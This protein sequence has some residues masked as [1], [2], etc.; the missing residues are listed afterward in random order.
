VKLNE[1]N[2]FLSACTS[3]K[4]KAVSEKFF[5]GIMTGSG[6]VGKTIFPYVLNISTP[7]AALD[8]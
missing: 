7:C 6:S 1:Y 3:G 4:K 2:P 5:R 8:P